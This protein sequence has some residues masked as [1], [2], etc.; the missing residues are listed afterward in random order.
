MISAFNRTTTWLFFKTAMAILSLVLQVVSVEECTRAWFLQSL[1]PAYPLAVV[2]AE[3]RAVS[4]DW[5]IHA[6]L[7][8]ETF[9]G[10]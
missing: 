1:C 9:N 10:R 3:G 5:T 6:R 4:R 2:S 7:G 8:L